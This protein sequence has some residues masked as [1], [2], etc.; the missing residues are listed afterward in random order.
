M[1]SKSLQCQ[2]IGFGFKTKLLSALQLLCKK[3]QIKSKGI[4][5]QIGVSKNQNCN[6]ST[7]K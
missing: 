2:N 6:K 1:S 7:K 3:H 4:T 5:G